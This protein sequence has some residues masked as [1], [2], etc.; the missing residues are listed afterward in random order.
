MK[1][2]VGGLHVLLKAS[3][4][5][6]VNP[7][8]EVIDPLIAEAMALREGVIFS[9]LRGFSRLIFEVDCLEV[10]NLWNSRAVLRSVIAP[11]LL[12]IE[13]LVLDFNSFV[14]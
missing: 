7:F 2:G 10:V 4:L 12:N 3:S 14:I 5:L 13:G 11:I 9:K 1:G 8:H 6:G